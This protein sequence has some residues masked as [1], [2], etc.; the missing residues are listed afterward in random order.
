MVRRI[1]WQLRV[2]IILLLIGALS[3]MT[4]LA[5]WR[6]YATAKK[7]AEVTKSRVRVTFRESSSQAK[8]HASLQKF[9]K[10][11]SAGVVKVICHT[12]EGARPKTGSGFFVSKSGLVVTNWHTISSRFCTGISIETIGGVELKAKALIINPETD[13]AILQPLSPTIPPKVFS[14]SPIDGVKINQNIITIGH[15]SSRRLL[16]STGVVNAIRTAAEFQEIIESKTSLKHKYKYLQIDLP[17]CRSINGAAVLNEKEQVIGIVVGG[18]TNKGTGFA[19]E[20][21]AIDDLL[22]KAKDAVPIGAAKISLLSSTGQEESY[23]GP[24]TDGKEIA[25]AAELVKRSLYC[26]KCHGT[27]VITKKTEVPKREL[28]KELVTGPG[29]RPHYRY[30]WVTIIKTEEQTIPCPLCFGH[31]ITPKI[32]ILYRHLCNLVRTM[33]VIN[34]IDEQIS[35]AWDKAVET[36]QESAFDNIWYARGLTKN[37]RGILST[38][39]KH[40]GEPVVFIGKLLSAKPGFNATYLT[41]VIYETNQPVYVWSPG[42]ISA[43]EGQWC[44]V[45]GAIGGIVESIPLVMAVDVAGLH[46]N[47]KLKQIEPKPKH[48]YRRR[49]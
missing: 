14:G 3:L 43:L 39:Q 11:S 5:Q 13:L 41:V 1:T 48:S 32:D 49:R 7:P 15:S 20:W 44:Q 27:G 2:S 25:R 10:Q 19:I 26:G 37:V 36:L 12:S 34:E 24:A 4:S 21:K 29:I 47:P 28:Q 38:P 23:Y 35:T 42:N 18:I 40:L 45:A 33:S 9:F 22:K 16:V 6:T 30:K 8:K 31:G 46:V 17:V